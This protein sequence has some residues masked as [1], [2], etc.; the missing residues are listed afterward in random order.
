MD[1]QLVSTA[2]DIAVGI[3]ALIVAIVA[4]FGVRTWR[5]ELTG[6]AKFDVARNLMLLGIKLKADFEWARNPVGW[7]WEYASR[8]RQEGES[9]SAS[10]VLDQWYAKNRR[11]EPL[12]E[13]LQKLQEASWEAEILLGEDSGK[14]VSDAVAVHRRSYAELSSAIYDYF[15]TRHD[16]AIGRDVSMRQ[17]EQKELRKAIYSAKDVEFSKRIEEATTKLEIALQAYVK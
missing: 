11:L 8:T 3:S 1:A 5:K 6:K 4:F 9:P 12:V 17:G 14:Q 2:S 7:S 15:E 13:N 10:E 16:E